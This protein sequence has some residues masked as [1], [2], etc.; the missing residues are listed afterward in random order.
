VPTIRY[1][2]QAGLL[3]PVQRQAGGQRSYDEADIERLQFIRRCREFG[4]SI[5]DI[6]RLIA[7]NTDPQCSCDSLQEFGR[8]QLADVGRRLTE[9]LALQAQLGRIVNRCASSCAGGPVAECT[10]P[11]DLGLKRARRET[12]P[13]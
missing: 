13:A 6:Q 5:D 12:R 2:E 7:L 8:Q 4:F 1:C 10:I 3:R 9:L 11:F